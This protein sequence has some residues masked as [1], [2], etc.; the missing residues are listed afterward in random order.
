MRKKLIAIL[1]V[2]F[3]LFVT[4]SYYYQNEIPDYDSFVVQEED[5]I[6]K[7]KDSETKGEGNIYSQHPE[8]TT[9]KPL[10]LNAKSALLMDA[11]NSRVLYEKNGFN[12]MPMASTTK[13]MTCIYTLENGN[14]DDTVT[15]SKNAANQPKVRLGVREGD[16]YKLRDLLYA[17]MLESYNDCAVAIAEHVS[18]SVEQF[19]YDMSN[20]ARDLGAHETNFETPNGLDSENHYTTG[21]DLALITKYAISNP[22]FIEI[23]NCKSYTFPELKTGIDRTANNKNAFL[24]QYEGAIGVKTGFTGKA[25][26][27]FVGAVKQEDRTLISVVLASG[28]PPNKTFKWMDT[29]KLMNFGVKEFSPKAVVDSG[30]EFKNVNV[31]KGIVQSI[32][33]YINED[34]NMLLGNHESLDTYVAMKPTMKAPITV[35]QVI[36]SLEIKVDNKLVKEIPIMAKEASDKINYP[37]CIKQ[38]IMKVVKR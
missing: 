35:N 18:G 6:V 30:M 4:G 3:M 5:Q 32:T 38:I 19:C 24:H 26:Y 20:K 16:E 31:E 8:D 37:Y 9:V 36:G 15:I 23:I 7:E 14:L 1:L 13:I 17:L 34:Y 27:C 29:S 28:W 12:K 2:S 11:D 33:P 22:Q 25:G 10:Q 21:F